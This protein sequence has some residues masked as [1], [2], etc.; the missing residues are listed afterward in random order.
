MPQKSMIGRQQR[1]RDDAREDARHR[2]EL[3]RV[4]GHRLERVDLL[5]D[6]H[7]AEL[8]ADAR[9]RRG[10][11]RAAP[12]T[13]GPVSRIS[14]MARPAGIIASAPKRSSDARVCIDSTTPMAKPDGGDQ[15]R[16]APADLEDVADDFAELVG[17]AERLEQRADAEERHLAHPGEGG[18]NQR[19]ESFEHGPT[20]V[21]RLGQ[22]NSR[23]APVSLTV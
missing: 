13:S 12:V 19:A 5:G 1:Q 8:G 22:L 10:P 16:R 2:E 21:Q 14:A 17:R 3:E 4:D 9:R 15:R 23:Q 18:E 20:V 6:L 7:R 11:T